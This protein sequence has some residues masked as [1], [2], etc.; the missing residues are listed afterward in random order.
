M[1][2][3][4]F[5]ELLENDLDKEEVYKGDEKHLLT[6]HLSQQSSNYANTNVNRSQRDI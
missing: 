5:Y 4:Q 3:N 6:K 2:K 1:N